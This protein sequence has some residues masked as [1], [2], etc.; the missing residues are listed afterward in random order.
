MCLDGLSSKVPTGGYNNR[1][2]NWAYRQQH[3]AGWRRREKRRA[4]DLPVRVRDTTKKKKKKKKEVIHFFDGGQK[5]KKKKRDFLFGVF[6]TLYRCK[7]KKKKKIRRGG[8]CVG[9][10]HGCAHGLSIG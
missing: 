1:Q 9:C 6:F 5:K 8:F 4:P 2:H 10:A 7:G 3:T